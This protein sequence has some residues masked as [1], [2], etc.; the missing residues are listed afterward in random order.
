MNIRIIN[1]CKRH[2]EV[3]NKVRKIGRSANGSNRP[4]EKRTFPT[5]V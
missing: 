4:E 2:R 1:A 3:P 5:M